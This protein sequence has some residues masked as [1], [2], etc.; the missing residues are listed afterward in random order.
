LRKI[1]IPKTVKKWIMIIINKNF[2]T[3]I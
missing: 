3:L 2:F 1:K